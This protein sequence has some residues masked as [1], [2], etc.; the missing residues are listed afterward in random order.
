MKSK[1]GELITQKLLQAQ[2]KKTMIR[3]SK[4]TS[5]DNNQQPLEREPELEYDDDLTTNEIEEMRQCAIVSH[6]AHERLQFQ[7]RKD[8]EIKVTAKDQQE[9]WCF[10]VSKK[11]TTLNE[12]G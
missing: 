2:L 3:T 8:S 1:I 12:H 6:M 4:G 5:P 7:K 9:S 10:N 11:P